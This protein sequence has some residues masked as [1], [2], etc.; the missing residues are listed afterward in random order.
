MT[1]LE[2]DRSGDA[3]RFSPSRNGAASTTLGGRIAAILSAAS[4]PMRWLETRRLERDYA[5]LSD[6]RLAD[7][8]VD[9]FER[10]VTLRD[11]GRGWLAMPVI[12]HGYLRHDRN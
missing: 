8:G 2:F 3:G 4:A 9:R 1:V 7:I 6:T 10:S 12:D 11:M 5:K